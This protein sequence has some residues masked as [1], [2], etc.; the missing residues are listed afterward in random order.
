MRSRGRD[1]A[2]AKWVFTH[3]A[4]GT[5]FLFPV[6]ERYCWVTISTIAPSLPN[7]LH[8]AVTVREGP[9]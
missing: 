9:P 5:K 1:N 8:R 4:G 7:S 6:A 3:P 2:A